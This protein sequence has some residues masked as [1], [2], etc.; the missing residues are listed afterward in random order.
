LRRGSIG[1]ASP[2]KSLRLAVLGRDFAYALL[3]D[4]AETDETALQ[5]SL[6]RL[7]DAD[8]LFVEGAPPQANYRFK[9]SFD[10]GSEHTESLARGAV[11]WLWKV[12]ADRA[13][14]GLLHLFHQGI[15][16][17]ANKA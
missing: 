8:L 4:V 15:G 6:D 9:G 17:L 3:R 7:A 1:S 14:A 11:L 12:E 13:A 16:V 2:A 10:L 5:A